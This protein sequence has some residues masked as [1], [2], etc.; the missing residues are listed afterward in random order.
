LKETIAA[1]PFPLSA[2]NRTFKAILAKLNPPREA[3][4]ECVSEKCRN[5]R[6]TAQPAEDG[7]RQLYPGCGY[8]PL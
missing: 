1:D 5:Q 7:N 2:R 4:M 8:G 3:S 6:K